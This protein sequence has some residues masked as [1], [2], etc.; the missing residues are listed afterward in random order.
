MLIGNT[1]KQ[2]MAWERYG[3]SYEKYMQHVI[4]GCIARQVE[5]III[6]GDNESKKIESQPLTNARVKEKV[7]TRSSGHLSS[8]SM[9]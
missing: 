5:K 7:G 2:K 3:C 4:D 8:G 9:Y 6:E 1:K